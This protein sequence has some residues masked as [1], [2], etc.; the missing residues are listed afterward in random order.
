MTSART[1]SSLPES[2]P[3]ARRFARDVLRDQ[4][5]DLVDAA[6]LMVSE[7]ATNCVQHAHTDFE[8]TI[9]TR[10]E[11]RVEVRDAGHGR[12]EVQSPPPLAPSGR[13]LRIVQ[14]I[15]DAWG[16]IPS[17]SGKTVWFALNL[18]PATSTDE[19]GGRVSSGRTVDKEGPSVARS[20][21]HAE[22]RAK[23]SGR[24]RMTPRGRRFIA[25]V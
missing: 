21:C 13:G 22:R 24:V 7:L 14:E 18:Q 20:Q 9:R 10:D 16:I 4:S 12:P 17:P 19:R 2:V 5:S 8:I 15:S 6:E 1:F 25:T 3:A 11:V 23:P